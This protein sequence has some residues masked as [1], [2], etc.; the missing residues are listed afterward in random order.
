[1]SIEENRNLSQ[2]HEEY[3]K[4]KNQIINNFI[5]STTMDFA[6]KI[7][8]TYPYSLEYSNVSSYREHFKSIFQIPAYPIAEEEW[9]IIIEQIN[10][11]LSAFVNEL[12]KEDKIKRE[13]LMTNIHS[14]EY[15][16]EKS[17]TEDVSNNIP[18]TDDKHISNNS[19]DITSKDNS[20]VERTIDNNLSM[21]IAD[22]I[23]WNI[24]FDLQEKYNQGY[25]DIPINSNTLISQ[26]KISDS[27]AQKLATEINTMMQ[28]YIYEKENSKKNY[29]PY[30]LDGFEEESKGMHR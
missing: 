5:N 28:N 26:Y 2:A 23:K 27:V 14:Q 3:L 6:N 19:P 8:S 12:I 4:R 24:I 30:Y 15:R 10:Q 17:Y 16:E 22:E 13:S 9:D 18:T 7:Y 25:P 21:M 29:Q 11:K 20:S 1:M